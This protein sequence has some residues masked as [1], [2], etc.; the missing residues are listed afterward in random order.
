[1]TIVNYGFTANQQL[2]NGSLVLGPDS[3]KARKHVDD[4]R[5][6][7]LLKNS[8]LSLTASRFIRKALHPAS[9]LSSPGIPDSNEVDLYRTTFRTTHSQTANSIPGNWDCMIW[10]PPGDNTSCIVAVGLAGVDFRTATLT[11]ATPPAAGAV[12]VTRYTFNDNLFGAGH[13]GTLSNFASNFTG[14][15]AFVG[16]PVHRYFGVST[17]SLMPKRWRTTS[18]S[19]T[20]N[21]IANATQNQGTVYAWEGGRSFS[22]GPV[23]EAYRGTALAAIGQQKNACWSEPGTGMLY[24]GDLATTAS[25]APFNNDDM[26]EM[27]QTK[28]TSVPFDETDMIAQT[29]DLYVTNAYNGV[30]A[31]HRF[32]GPEQPLQN[33]NNLPSSVVVPATAE[34]NG[35]I[36]DPAFDLVTSNMSTFQQIPFPPVNVVPMSTTSANATFGLS[37][38]TSYTPPP[39]MV[40]MALNIDD[41]D[42][43]LDNMSQ[44][45]QIYRSLDPSATLQIK[46][47][48]SLEAAPME[49]SPARPFVTPALEYEPEALTM[50]YRVA[51]R[52]H[53][54]HPAD[55][56]DFGE[57]V[58]RIASVVKSVAA[59]LAAIVSGVMPEIAPV[60]TIVGSGATSLASA[61]QTATAKKRAKV[62]KASP[63]AAL[64]RPQPKRPKPK[65]RLVQ[66]R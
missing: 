8:G 53:A 34:Q 57:I 52:V 49:S 17:G 2:I 40:T 41:P 35:W 22:D 24:H 5:V 36:S 64:R 11:A 15:S 47:I 16:P 62:A 14:G 9:D 59:P 31:V 48:L 45:V 58:H 60:A 1:M 20:V 19:V 33:S 29:P 21:L 30:Y 65:V 6:E 27:V 39:W 51:H 28:Y 38:N 50:Y 26:H 10:C 61:V 12:N 46:R 25:L 7:S 54:V 23:I 3:L 43:S 32:L 18:S 56:N 63:R 37:S 13:L 42:T 55:Y 44:S 66:R 4:S